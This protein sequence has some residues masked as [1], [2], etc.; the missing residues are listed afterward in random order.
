MTVSAK[1]ILETFE[2][3]VPNLSEMDQERL[4]SFGE[5]L[6]FKVDRDMDGHEKDAS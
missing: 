2:K 4:L 5:G 6:A 1:K 3:I